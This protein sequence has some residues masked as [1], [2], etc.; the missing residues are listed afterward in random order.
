MS[1]AGF[2]DV[3]F[4]VARGQILGVAGVEGNG[5]RELMSALAGIYPSKGSIRLK[6]R[7][8]DHRELLKE[9]ALMP[10]DRL[11]EGLAGSLNVRENAT[12][13]P[14]PSLPTMAF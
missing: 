6:G 7:S 4:N 5:Q 1:G 3:S 2:A 12:F 8:L 10:S 11:R 14:C 13:P 9:A